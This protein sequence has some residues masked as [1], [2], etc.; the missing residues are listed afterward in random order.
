MNQVG[1]K[2]KGQIEKFKQRAKQEN[3]QEVQVQKKFYEMPWFWICTSSIVGFNALF[4]SPKKSLLYWNL[5]ITPQKSISMAASLPSENRYFR[6]GF[7]PYWTT[8]HLSGNGAYTPLGSPYW[9]YTGTMNAV[10]CISSIV[11]SL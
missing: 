1:F 4:V 11:D 10:L 5:V 9:S 6:Y 3:K 2:K 8:E 7:L